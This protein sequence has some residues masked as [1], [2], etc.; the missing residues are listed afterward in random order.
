MLRLQQTCALEHTVPRTGW[1]VLAGTAL[2]VASVVA[3]SAVAPSAAAQVDL[4]ADPPKELW[5]EFPLNPKGERLV[6]ERQEKEAQAP[7]TPPAKAE[8]VPE[9]PSESSGRGFT[10]LVALGLAGALLLLALLAVGT[11]RLREAAVRRRR[12]APL[13]QG[14]AGIEA[15]PVA[16]LQHYADVDVSLPQPSRFSRVEVAPRGRLPE[17]RLRLPSLRDPGAVVRR[18]RRTVWSDS[19]APFIVGSAIAIVAAF[20]II[21]VIG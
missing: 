7:F 8:A 6:P 20:L 2:I 3:L 12:S 18:L 14:T 15:S 13:W 10:T 9:T 17:R 4:A 19:T 5:S 16:R 21:Y 1:R 11:V